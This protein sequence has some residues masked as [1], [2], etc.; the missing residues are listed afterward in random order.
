MKKLKVLIA[1]DGKVTVE[2]EGYTGPSCAEATRKVAEALGKLDWGR[3]KPE[4]FETEIT[5]QVTQSQG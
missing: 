3:A 4:Y 2:A 5:S 1:K